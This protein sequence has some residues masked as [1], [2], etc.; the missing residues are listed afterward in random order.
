MANKYYALSF[1]S[2]ANF[3]ASLQNALT[4]K[5]GD[6]VEFL[7]TGKAASASYWHEFI[8]RCPQISDKCIS[9]GCYDGNVRSIGA[10][11]GD[12]V[13][14]N[15][16][17]NPVRFAS[18]EAGSKS[19]IAYSMV[20]GDT[21]L[22][23]D[24]SMNDFGGDIIVGKTN[25]GVS[26][27][28]GCGSATGSSTVTNNALKNTA[29][30]SCVKFIS[31]NHTVYGSAHMPYKTKLLIASNSENTLLTLPDGT[32]DTIE[33]LY[34][35]MYAGTAPVCTT[36]GL[37]SRRNTY[38]NGDGSNAINTTSILAEFDTE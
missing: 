4:D 3:Q 5:Y 6:G 16:M 8:F 7:F 15:K 36:S 33:G 10:F 28:C 32:P 23:I 30:G 25:G 29:D 27:C 21:F 9:I 31:Y 2:V 38:S 11:Y 13:E 20:L 12:G 1:D 35:S 14:S 24:F 17:V 34:M 19:P 22:F 37:F 26:L 18:V